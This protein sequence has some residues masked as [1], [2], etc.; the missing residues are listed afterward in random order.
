MINKTEINEKYIHKLLSNNIKRL[1]N[2]DE[3][4]SS[5]SGTKNI[6]L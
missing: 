2:I 3:Y 4:Y 1:R 5:V 6:E